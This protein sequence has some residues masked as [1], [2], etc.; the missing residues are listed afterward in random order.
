M[1]QRIKVLLV[2]FSNLGDKVGVDEAKD[3]GIIS[4]VL[5]PENL[6]QYAL[7][8]AENLTMLPQV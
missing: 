8:V 2:K 6:L 7:K 4:Q 5:E 3:Q 1:K